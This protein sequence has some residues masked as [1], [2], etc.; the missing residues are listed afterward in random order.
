ME[1]EEP[2]GEGGHPAWGGSA[3][4]AKQPPGELEGGERGREMHEQVGGV[5]SGG[6]KPGDRVVQRERKRGQR[7]GR[8]EASRFDERPGC[9][10][11]VADRERTFDRR[12]VV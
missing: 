1:T 8:A 9:S 5:E 3:G 4:E 11:K 2:R 12:R 7:P 10:T 6:P